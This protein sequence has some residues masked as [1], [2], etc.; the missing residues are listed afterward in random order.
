MNSDQQPAPTVLLCSL[1]PD[2]LAQRGEDWRAVNEACVERT[3]QPGL[4]TRRYRRGPEIA[5]SL[6]R[7]IAAEAECCPFLHFDL[8]DVGGQLQ[9]EVTTTPHG[10]EA[11]LEALASA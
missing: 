10:A 5:Q 7:L 2:E 3:V 1:Q 4:L 6:R 8:Q 11:V 9:L